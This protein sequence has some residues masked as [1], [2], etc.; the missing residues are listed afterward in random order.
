M[1]FL[2]PSSSCLLKL[3]VVLERTARKCTKMQYARAELLFR[4]LNL[5][6]C[7]VLV[8]VFVVKAP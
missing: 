8:A 5:L 1:G 6:L 2:L 3:P 4:S 7:G